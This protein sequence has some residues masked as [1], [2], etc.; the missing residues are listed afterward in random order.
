MVGDK[1]CCRSCVSID[2]GRR[3]FSNYIES[4]SIQS[5]GLVVA[6]TQPIKWFY[7]CMCPHT[8]RHF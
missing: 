6:A 8:F 1:C 3:A 5:G 2:G 7:F 4:S